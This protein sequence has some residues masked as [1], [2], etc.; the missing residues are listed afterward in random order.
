MTTIVDGGNDYAVKK[1]GVSDCVTLFQYI[2][3]Y[4]KYKIQNKQLYNLM[5]N[6]LNNFKD[7]RD[8]EKFSNFIVILEPN[9]NDNDGYNHVVIEYDDEDGRLLIF[10]DVLDNFMSWFPLDEEDSQMFIKN[11][12]E[13]TFNVKVKYIQS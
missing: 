8:V 11:W 5:I 2:Y 12:F 1:T 4:M 13:E 7:N 10:K 9:I 6:Y 3:P